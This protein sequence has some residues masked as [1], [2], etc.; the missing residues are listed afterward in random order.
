MI[1]NVEDVNI[2][3]FVLKI[4]VHAPKILTI[5]STLSK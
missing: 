4:S 1:K 3:I 2:K 5:T